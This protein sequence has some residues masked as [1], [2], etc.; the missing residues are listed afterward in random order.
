MIRELEVTSWNLRERIQMRELVASHRLKP[1]R[2]LRMLEE[3]KVWKREAGFDRTEI[4]AETHVQRVHVGFDSEPLY[5]GLYNPQWPHTPKE[6]NLELDV[7]VERLKLKILL[8]G[9]PTSLQDDLS[10]GQS[11]AAGTGLD[12]PG[13]PHAETQPDQEGIFPFQVDIDG[14]LHVICASILE[15]EG[16]LSFQAGIGVNL[17]PVTVQIAARQ[18]A[19][20]PIG[21]QQR[22]T[23]ST[24]HSKQFNPGG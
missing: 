15:Q 5:T 13:V 17:E 21:W 23:T 22:G 2:C 24:G 4:M 8:S 18:L 1:M 10:P 20:L 7:E 16:S 14:F 12:E 19:R 6:Y 9:P 11:H 3:Q